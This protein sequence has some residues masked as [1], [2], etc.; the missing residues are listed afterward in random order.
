M[1]KRMLT[2]CSGG[3]HSSASCCMHD[4]LL[5]S[6]RPADVSLDRQIVV[7]GGRAR[8]WLVIRPTH[9]VAT[10][11]GMGVTSAHRPHLFVGRVVRESGGGGRWALGT[12]QKHIPQLGRRVNKPSMHGQWWYRALHFAS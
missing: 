9:A 11:R 4:L 3:G 2:P 7:C 1:K 5:P 10:W 8:R 6:P 12:A